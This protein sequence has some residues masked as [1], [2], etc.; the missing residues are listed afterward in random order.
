VTAFDV[1]AILVLMISAGVGFVRGGTREVVTVLAF[2]L[3]VAIAVFGL[4][5]TGPLAQKAIHPAFLAEVT[6]GLAVFVAA[7]ALLW[8]AGRALMRGIRETE[9]LS[10][11]DRA[12]GVGFGL[13][14]ALVLLGVFYLLFNIATPPERAPH[15]IRGAA[16]YPLSGA[17]GHVLMALAPKG[18]AMAGRV[19]PALERALKVDASDGPAAASGKGPGYDERSRRSV[20]DLVE[21]TR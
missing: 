13:L 8:L 5:F 4:R 21:K 14:R 6:A 20:D 16:L 15:W 10:G 9:M 11:L 7:Y 2:A 1:I 17:A 3:S 19:A 18:Q 12:A